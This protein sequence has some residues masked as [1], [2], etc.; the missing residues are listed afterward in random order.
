M[1]LKSVFAGCILLCVAGVGCA[2]S[3]LDT[4]LKSP[5][6]LRSEVEVPGVPFVAQAKNHCGPASV[7]MMLGWAGESVSADA[8]AEQM[9]TPGKSGT[10]QTDLIG[11]IRRRGYLAVPIRN[12][13]DLFT[14]I[15]S[16][17]PVLVF[18][19]L[20][21]SWYPQWHYAVA[22]GYDLK[23]R[24]L[25]LHS[26]QD[27]RTQLSL[28]SFEKSWALAGYWALAVLPPTQLAATA[29]EITN[30]DAISPLEEAGLHQ[31]AQTA[32]LEV[33]KR[34]PESLGGWVGVGNTRFALH[35]LKGSVAA[36]KKASALHPGNAGIW[37]N[38]AFGY[39]ELGRTHEAKKAAQQALTL[40]TPDER[41]IFIESLKSIVSDSKS[42]R[43]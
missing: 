40:A 9:Y 17:H 23:E 39:F 43:L 38:L 15:E 34:W 41:P 26:G 33:L 19:N 37:H 36:L 24:E 28:R 10:L 32:Y 14:E 25:L 11:A 5:S 7:A 35:D 31:R 16:G 29:N 8:L 27:A 13:R 1:F 12:L 30:L 4:I 3:Q 21:L 42:S 6:G 18:M 2:T 20:G 22:F